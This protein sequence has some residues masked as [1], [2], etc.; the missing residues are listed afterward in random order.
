MPITILE[1]PVDLFKIK[2]QAQVGK[3]EYEGV[4]DAGRKILGKYGWKGAF[5]G[6]VPTMWRNIPC[7]GT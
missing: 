4:I 7:F 1:T 3:G 6:F 5:Q 2:L